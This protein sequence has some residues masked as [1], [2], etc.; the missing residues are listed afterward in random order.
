MLKTKQRLLYI[1]CDYF[2]VIL[3]WTLF[4]SFRKEIIEKG[5]FTD[6]WTFNLTYLLAIAILPICWIVLHYLVGYYKEVF[7][8]SRTQELQQTF[9]ATFIGVTVLF[10]A[11]V[12]DDYISDYKQ[13]YLLYAVMFFLFFI[14]TLIPRMIITNITSKKIRKN[15]I[16]FNTLI[17]GDSKN[18]ELYYLDLQ[19]QKVNYGINIVGYVSFYKSEN[20]YLSNYIPLLGKFDSILDIINEYKIEDVIIAVESKDHAKIRTILYKLQGTNVGLNIIPDI[21]DIILGKVRTTT[22]LGIPLLKINKNIMPVWQQYVKVIFD[23]TAS[24]FAVILLSPLYLFLAILVKSDSKG[25][26][27][28]KQERIGKHGKKFNIIKFRTMYVNSESNGPALSSK[29]D[30]RITKV[31]KFLRKVRLDETPQFFNVLRGDMSLVGPRPERQFY[32]EKIEKIAPY[33]IYNQSV[34]PGITSWGQVKY[35]YASNVNEMVKR[36]RYDIL[37]LENRSLGLD[38][39]ILL[40]TVKIVFLRKGL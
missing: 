34:K 28:F 8:K 19:K 16:K 33:V 32:I 31:G 30:S 7:R 25:P 14:I 36:L 1:L 40:L 4:Y 13:Y 37:Y 11:T 39:K 23:F 24:L 9:V 6:S 15:I 35:G 38:L 26:I 27:F 17:I 18:A 12:L 29:N 21:Y 3:A 2:A 10:F 20:Q 5:V 22:I